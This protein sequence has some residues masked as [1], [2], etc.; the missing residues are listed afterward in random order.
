[1]YTKN[2]KEVDVMSR[3]FISGILTGSMIGATAS[4]VAMKTMT[5]RQRKKMMKASRKVMSNVLSNMRIF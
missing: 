3:R 2:K 4:M 5:P 1:M